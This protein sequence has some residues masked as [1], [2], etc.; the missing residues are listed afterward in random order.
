MLTI[1]Q[2]LA[3][4]DIIEASKCKPNKIKHIAGQI[5]VDH[6]ALIANNMPINIYIIG[7]LSQAKL[8]K[9]LAKQLKKE[10][11]HFNVKYVHK[12]KKSIKTVIHNCF[13]K[14]ASSNHIVAVTKPDGSFGRGTSYEIKFAKRIGTPIYFVNPKDVKDILEK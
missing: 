1:E 9:K 12:K 11:W 5:E 10:N 13:D 6:A 2:K 3:R 4:G 7:S 8:I 14:I